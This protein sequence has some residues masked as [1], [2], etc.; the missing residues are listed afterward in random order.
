MNAYRNLVRVFVRDTFSLKR[1]LGFDAKHAKVKAMVIGLALI[2][3]IVALFGTIGWM[4]FDLSRALEA[5]GQGSLVMVFLGVY[6]V[7]I[8]LVMALLR[9]NGMVFHYKD[10]DFLAALPVTTRTIVAAKL[11]I[12]MMLV[13][14]MSVLLAL[15]VAFAY[16]YHAGVSMV[17]LLFVLVGVLALPVLPALVGAF[18]AL[19]LARL[20]VRYRSAHVLNILVMFGVLIGFFL[21]SFSFGDMGENPLLAQQAFMET[22]ERVYPFFV[23]FSRAVAEG[24]VVPMLGV[25]MG[26]VVPIGLFLWCASPLVSAVNRLARSGVKKSRKSGYHGRVSSPFVALVH[27]EYRKFISTPIYALNVG[28]GPILMAVMAIAAVFYR[29]GVVSMLEGLIGMDGALEATVL[30]VVGFTL[31]MVYSAAISLSLEG[32]YFWVVRSLPI[33]GATLMQAKMVFNLLLG[34]PIS[35][36]SVWLFAWSF[37]IPLINVVFMTLLVMAFAVLKTSL[38]AIINLYMPKFNFQNDVE[39]VKQSVGAFLGVFGGFALMVMNALG[40][41]GLTTVVSAPLALA[42]LSL[43]NGVLSVPLIVYINR[44]S[45]ALIYQMKST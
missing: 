33:R 30:L 21:A 41:V 18:I 7:V 22:L 24:A 27:K 40:F 44:R 9:A 20:L 34:V 36:L 38:D 26:A 45:D 2:Y 11:T 15:P 42:L 8:A 37:G 28:V 14:V 35:I 6:I 32:K 4:F 12:F 16:F 39:V 10:Y 19:G 17:G 1:L 13:M 43:A 3:A 29:E 25:V 5:M 23:W 31:S